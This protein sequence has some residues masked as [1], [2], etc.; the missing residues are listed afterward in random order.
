MPYMVAASRFQFLEH[1]LAKRQ[2]DRISSAT[3]LLR[4]LEVKYDQPLY[5]PF[6]NLYDSSIPGFAV[7]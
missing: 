2:E 4:Q 6:L 3:E 1:A 5:A 7:F